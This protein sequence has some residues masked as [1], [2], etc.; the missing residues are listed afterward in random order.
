[1]DCAG[2]PE[3]SYSEFGELI[4]KKTAGR[5][6]PLK[7]SL[8]LTLQC[9]LRCKHCY[10]D[11]VHD[12]I[13]GEQ[14]LSTEEWYDIL[15]QLADAGTLWL[16]MT[17]GEPF[18]R[19]DFLDIYTYAK[20]RG[21][22]ITIFTNGTLITPEIADYLADWLGDILGGLSKL[23][24]CWRT[25][26][27]PVMGGHGRDRSPVLGLRMVGSFDPRRGHYAYGVFLELVG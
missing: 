5:R 1:V 7:G 24:G 26:T 9:N 13:P 3:L 16:L 27:Q 23:P 22:L 11:G 21:F 25:P 10:L 12:G 2:I 6:V 4:S 18:A 8:E 20:K 14:E 19:S 17:G 15:D